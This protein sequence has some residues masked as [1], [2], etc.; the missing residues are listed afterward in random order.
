[1]EPT[2]EDDASAAPPPL[3]VG[4]RVL[5]ANATP[6][7]A[8]DPQLG[9]KGTVQQVDAAGGSYLVRWEDGSESWARRDQLSPAGRGALARPAGAPGTPAPPRGPRPSGPRGRR[10]GLG[11][12]VGPLVFLVIVAQGVIRPLLRGDHHVDPG[13][14]V[15]VAFIALPF[16]VAILRRVRG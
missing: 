4:G 12:V 16:L 10:S 8:S 2:P 7:F 15:V 14:L 13:A 5:S 6:T 11:G 9:A 3:R 1:M